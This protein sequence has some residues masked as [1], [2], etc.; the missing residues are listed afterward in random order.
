MY[1]I[2]CLV[3]E[4]H[5]EEVKAAMFAGGAGCM[6]N[7]DCCCFCTPGVGQFRPCEGAQPFIG[8]HNTVEY[9]N[10]VKIE[11]ACPTENILTAIAAIRR[12]HPYEHPAFAYWKIDYK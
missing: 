2:E 12:S 11:M 3:P 6:G 10:E 9:V 8:E 1:K 7:Y 5:V 4:T